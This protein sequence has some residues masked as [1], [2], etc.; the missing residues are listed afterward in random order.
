MEAQSHDRPEL[1]LREDAA[2][3]T[4]H[5]GQFGTGRATA[6]CLVQGAARVVVAETSC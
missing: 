2:V 6:V 1:R 4:G 3:V 5:E